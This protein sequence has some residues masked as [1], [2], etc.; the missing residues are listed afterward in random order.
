MNLSYPELTSL[1]DKGHNIYEI[2]KDVVYVRTNYSRTKRG[3]DYYTDPV[4][5]VQAFSDT[6]HLPLK[7]TKQFPPIKK[8]K[9]SPHH[10][11]SW[12][13]GYSASS[14]I[15]TLLTTFKSAG[16]PVVRIEEL[17]NPFGSTYSL[18]F[19]ANIGDRK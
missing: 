12:G 7:V 14:D 10:R 11:W 6:N 13:A 3:G 9:T 18:Y 17:R 1:M 16:Y 19:V 4:L 5:Q 8:L 2:W 15:R